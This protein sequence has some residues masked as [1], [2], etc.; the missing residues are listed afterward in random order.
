MGPRH[1]LCRHYEVVTTTGRQICIL[2]A[3]AIDLNA[4]TH[5]EAATEVGEPGASW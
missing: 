4:M 5:A 2:A 1:R 3:E